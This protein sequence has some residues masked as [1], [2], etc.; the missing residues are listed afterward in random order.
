MYL[1]MGDTYTLMLEVSLS[2]YKS[3][4]SQLASWVEDSH[5]PMHD[6]HRGC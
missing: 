5:S 6:L 4:N 1:L 2:I 3:S